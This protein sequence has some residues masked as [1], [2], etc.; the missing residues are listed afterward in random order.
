MSEWE[1]ARTFVE[2]ALSIDKHLPGYVD[3]YFGP[4]EIRETVNAK[5]KVP[6]EELSTTLD[7]ITASTRQ[8]AKIT[9]ER[10][11]Y[12]LAELNGMRTT[13]KILRGEEIDILEEALG[14]FGL[15]PIWTDE[16]EFEEAH[17]LLDE[18]LPGSGSLNG[19]AQT[20]IHKKSIK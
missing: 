19:S 6:L 1:G 11:E 9:E 7:Q 20:C 2:L 16:S 17:Q 3:A 13:F 5:G 15:T 10:R 12:L 4:E 14:L 18:L 8:D